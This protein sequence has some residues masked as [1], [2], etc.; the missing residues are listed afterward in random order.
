M[1]DFKAVPGPVES[2]HS[3]RATIGGNAI[4][5]A[6]MKVPQCRNCGREQLLFLQFDIDE[7]WSLPF[8]A[9]SHFVLF[10]CPKCNEI[11]SFETFDQGQLPSEFWKQSEGHFFASLNEPEGKE[12]V[13]SAEAILV[14]L[15]LHFEA[16]R[17]DGHAPDTIRVGGRP[18]WLQDPE[19]FTCQCGAELVLISQI[20]EGYGFEKL[21]DAPEQPD[22]FSF[23]AYCLFLGNEIY[24]FG[25]PNQCHPRSVW[26][27]VQG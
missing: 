18:F 22:S 8:R 15:E 9:G 14:P 20:A 25:C 1:V 26:I 6:E 27:T 2:H 3:P 12:Q 13:Q 21:S 24:I 11:P 7:A 5:P 4:L 16:M 19:R 17:A 10:M 23:D